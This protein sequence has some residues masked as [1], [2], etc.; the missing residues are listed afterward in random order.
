MTSIRI[1]P[2]SR[3]SVV[4]V[5]ACTSLMLIGLVL[6][7]VSLLLTR[8]ARATDYFLNYRRAQLAAQ[9]CIDQL[10]IGNVAAANATFTDQTGVTYAIQVFDDSDDSWRPLTPVWVTAS[11]VGKHGRTVRYRLGTYLADGRASQGETR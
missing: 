8:Y 7:M 4:L 3:R 10:R 11:V 9:S 1:H 2:P 5:E 6:G